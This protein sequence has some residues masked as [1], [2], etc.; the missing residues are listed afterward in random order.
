M[1]TLCD[2]VSAQVEQNGLTM[3]SFG[4]ISVKRSS[5]VAARFVVQV[6]VTV[7]SLPLKTGSLI[8]TESCSTPQRRMRDT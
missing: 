2:V 3:L 8:D 6:A 7:I 4:E 1:V 5:T